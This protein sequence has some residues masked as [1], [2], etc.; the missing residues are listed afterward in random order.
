MAYTTKTT[1]IPEAI[2]ID[3]LDTAYS[4]VVATMQ[5]PIVF[6]G[7]GQGSYLNL[8]TSGNI[9]I[10]GQSMNVA[11]QRP[12]KTLNAKELREELERVAQIGLN[13]KDK[14]INKTYTLEEIS[15]LLGEY[16]D[17]YVKLTVTLSQINP[18]APLYHDLVEGKAKMESIL[19][20]LKNRKDEMERELEERKKMLRKR[21][22]KEN[23]LYAQKYGKEALEI[24]LEIESIERQ[25]K[26]LK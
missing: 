17:T 19:K 25:V 18:T 22:T 4:T 14:I 20:K 9:G 13:M 1:N 3:E 11:F 15:N 6:G 10:T 21:H 12:E 2:T 24:K 7:F 26:R 5:H 23:R 16:E 8:T